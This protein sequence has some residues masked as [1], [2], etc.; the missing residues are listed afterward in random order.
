MPWKRLA[1]WTNDIVRFVNQ[2]S[3]ASMA[4]YKSMGFRWA[5]ELRPK[6]SERKCGSKKKE[7]KK[8]SSQCVEGLRSSFGVLS[9]KGG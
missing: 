8:R 1:A 9:L 6:A 3:R 4:R 7:R 5:P 2:V